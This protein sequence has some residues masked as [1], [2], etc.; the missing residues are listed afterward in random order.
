MILINPWML[1]PPIPSPNFDNDGEEPIGCL[2]AACGFI[3]S[4][5]IFA[6]L[7]YLY[8]TLTEGILP[9]ILITVDSVIIFP[10][11]VMCL[12]LLSIKIKNKMRC[13]IKKIFKKNKKILLP[14]KA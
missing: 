5:I 9:S 4:V 3:A 12:A 7:L 8:F 14:I 6:S 11:M 1:Y 2:G 13:N 10:I